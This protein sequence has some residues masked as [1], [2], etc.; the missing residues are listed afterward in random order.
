[1][2][3][4][5]RLPGIDKHGGVVGQRA[6]SVAHLKGG[7]GTSKFQ[8]HVAGAVRMG[9]QRPVHVKQGDAPETALKDVERT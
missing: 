1:M 8:Q 6:K 5:V 9:D 7:V 2:R 3:I 4:G